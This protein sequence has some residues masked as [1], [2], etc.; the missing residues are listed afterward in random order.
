MLGTRVVTALALLALILPTLFWLP[1]W[2][3]AGLTLLFLVVG[4]AEWLNLTGARR[5]AWPVA[6]SLGVLGVLWLVA[7]LPTP[8]GLLLTV[9]GAATLFWLA[10]APWWLRREATGPGA[11]WAGPALLAACW[12]SLVHLRGIGVAALLVAM[13]IV[14]VA[15]IGAYFVGKGF[16]RRKLAP[17]ISPGKSIEGAL[18][19]MG[20]V[21]VIG[22]S[23]AAAPSLADTLPARLV[24]T[25]G[26]WLAGV[27]LAAVAALSVVGDLVESL[28]KRGA[29]VKDSGRILPGHGGILDRIDALLPTM[30]LVALMHIGLSG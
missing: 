16:G 26:P 25:V 20:L 28:V 23:V 12:L 19:G 22:L 10:V 8:G 5:L 7:D 14:W 30:P 3:W 1:P 15:D 4:C 29:G 11:R 13:A 18:G 24:A 9:L 21:V 6:G 17:R 2:A 27:A